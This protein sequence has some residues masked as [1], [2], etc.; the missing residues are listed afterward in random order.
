MRFRAHTLKYNLLLV[1]RAIKGWQKY[2]QNMRLY[3]PV[4]EIEQS[5]LI[6]LIGISLNKRSAQTLGYLLLVFESFFRG[7]A[8]RVKE[9]DPH[10]HHE[11]THSGTCCVQNH[12]LQKLCLGRRTTPHLFNFKS[13]NMRVSLICNNQ[14]T[15]VYRR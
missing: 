13:T 8:I 9:S 6:Y 10:E 15:R 1:N 4:I 12:F 11:A 7:L 2:Q 5:I 3:Q 14:K